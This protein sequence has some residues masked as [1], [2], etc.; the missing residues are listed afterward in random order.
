[1]PNHLVNSLSPYLLQHAKNPVDWYPWGKEALTKARA[2]N[3][4][5]FLSIGYS[6]CHWCHVME[7]ESFENES[8]ANMLNQSFISIKVDREERPDLDDLYMDAVQLMTHRGGWPMSVWLTPDLKPFFA[9]TYFPP[10]TRQGMT[11]FIEILEQIKG[12][13]EKDQVKIQEQSIEVLSE[14]KRMAKPEGSSALPDSEIFT[15][16]LG[17]LEQDFDPIWGG[18]SKAPKFPQQMAIDL[19][20]RRGS[21]KHLEMADKTLDSMWQGGLFDHLAGGFA[22]Y[23][24]DRQWRIPHFEKM[25]YDNAQLASIYIEAYRKNKNSL[26]LSIAEKTLDYLIEDMTGSEGGIYSSEDADSEGEEG[27]FYAFT[28]D[29][30]RTTLKDKAAEFMDSFGVI[31]EGNFE[32][33]NILHRP[34]LNPG[35]DESISIKE[36]KQLLLKYRNLRTRPHRDDKILTSWN[37]LALSAFCKGYQSSG[38]VRYQQQ[39]LALAKFIID[40]MATKDNLM[41]VYRHG[42]VAIRGFLEDYAFFANGLIDLYEITF[43]IKWL[44]HAETI[45]GNMVDHF[46]DYESGGFYFN[47]KDD[48]DILFSVKQVYDNAVPSSN[49]LALLCLHRIHQHLGNPKYPS[50]IEQS[51]K[52]YGG[53]IEKRPRAMLGMLAVLDRILTPSI[54]IVIVGNPKDSWVKEALNM[55]YQTYLPNYAI[56]VGT[57]SI[58]PLLKDRGAGDTGLVYLCQNKTCLKPIS[59]LNELQLQ[60]VKGI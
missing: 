41:R 14:I 51:I 30:V 55:V 48:S 8:V 10:T 4:P 26:Y 19:I 44:H 49:T 12:I 21:A 57:D 37:G 29:E 2:E 60:L 40:H 20:L 52:S 43:D 53:W 54:E 1:M 9:G 23:A 50:L 42:Q 13:W 38:N 32:G 17:Q 3:K 16:V 33:K 31:P 5:I 59:D 11:G 28:Y 22:R 18:F 24:T 58:H 46:Y 39:A 7:H 47:H 35:Q 15:R 56:A 25:L 34:N 36:S 27:K 6:A 45:I